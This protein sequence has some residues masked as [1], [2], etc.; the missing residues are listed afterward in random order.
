MKKQ[1]ITVKNKVG[2]IVILKDWNMFWFLNFTKMYFFSQTLN[3]YSWFWS[4]TNVLLKCLLSMSLIFSECLLTC[5]ISISLYGAVVVRPAGWLKY[6]RM[7]KIFLFVWVMVS[8]KIPY[9][10]LSL[11]RILNQKYQ[12]YFFF[13]SSMFI[14]CFFSCKLLKRWI[15][16]KSQLWKHPLQLFIF[17]MLGKRSWN[18]IH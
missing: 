4:E 17:A 5:N 12:I 6:P 15:K 2:I 9:I 18:A 11:I 13:L 1:T 3:I 14:L 7:E 16:Y 10:S 8:M